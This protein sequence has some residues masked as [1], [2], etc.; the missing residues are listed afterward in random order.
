MKSEQLN[1]LNNN[2]NKSGQG[3]RISFYTLKKIY[4]LGEN[5]HGLI[6]CNPSLT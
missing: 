6:I 3:E 4:K 5:M 2:N 1:L